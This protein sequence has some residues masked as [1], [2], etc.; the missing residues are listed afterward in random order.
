MKKFLV[1]YKSSVP[2]A[3]QMA[4]ATPEQMKAGMDLWNAWAQ[5]AQ[6]AIVDLGMP[7]GNPQEIAGASVRHSDSKVAGFSILQ[8]ESERAVTD[9]LMK[10]PH[11]RAP[12][13][14]I[15]VLEMMPMPDM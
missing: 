8:A 11:H 9:L 6:K 15:E 12:G 4:S 2:A 13:A 5:Q 1:L 14:S 10:H 3:Q 7:L